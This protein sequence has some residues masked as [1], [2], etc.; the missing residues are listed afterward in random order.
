M[1]ATPRVLAF[2]LTI[3]LIGHAGAP[4]LSAQ[5]PV[6][7]PGTRIRF[8]LRNGDRY[9]GRVILLGPEV[10]ET[11][12][13]MNGATS[14]YPLSDISRMEVMRGRHRPILRFATVGLIAGGTAGAIIGAATYKSPDLF[15]GNR[16]DAALVAAILVG[17]AG[18]AV[19]GVQGS[20]PRD[21]WQRV[22]VDGNVVRFNMRA[23]PRSG[24]GIGLALA[25]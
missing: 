24:T 20:R 14:R 5:Q 17:V 23:L 1:Q 8:K 21:R 22:N 13:L 7:A 4:S 9:E 15:S 11:G 6:V 18:A 19:G 16:S 3:G 2:V 12:L 25:F 10:L